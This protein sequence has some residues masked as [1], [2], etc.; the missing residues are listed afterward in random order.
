MQICLCFREKQA[1]NMTLN[2]DKVYL[3]S[4]F[5]V[6]KACS[7]WQFPCIAQLCLYKWYIPLVINNTF[8]IPILAGWV[9]FYCRHWSVM[10]NRTAREWFL[11]EPRFILKSAQRKQ[12]KAGNAVPRSLK[13]K[14]L[15]CLKFLTDFK[16]Q[17]L[18]ENG[19]ICIIQ[20]QFQNASLKIELF[21]GTSRRILCVRKLELFGE[22]TRAIALPEFMY[23]FL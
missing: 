2:E 23:A 13:A 9:T 22:M 21:P 10:E 15:F 5:T 12:A 7:L 19:T 8:E 14:Q 20:S 18:E 17:L 4:S 3:V 1:K 16:H 6:S 11:W